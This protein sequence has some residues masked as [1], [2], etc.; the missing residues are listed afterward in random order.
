MQNKLNKLASL[1]I[2]IVLATEV[3]KSVKEWGVRVPVLNSD[4]AGDLL[5]VN[6]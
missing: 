3:Y 2:R 6:Q 1:V 5:G 4:G